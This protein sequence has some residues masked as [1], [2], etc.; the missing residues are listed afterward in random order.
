M[1]GVCC[2]GGLAGWVV[3]FFLGLRISKICGERLIEELMCDI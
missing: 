1:E 3:V 2:G